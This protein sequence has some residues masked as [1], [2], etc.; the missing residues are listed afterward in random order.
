MIGNSASG[1]DVT[2]ELVQTAK[3]PVYQSRRSKSRWDGDEPPIGIAWKPVIEEFFPDGRILFNDGTYLEDVDNIIYCT[4]YKPS[5]P[6]WNS[7]A[8]GRPLWDYEKGKL[9]NI[10]WHSFFQDFPTLGIVGMPRVLTFRSFEYQAI[11]FARLFSQ[12]NAATLPPI[13]EQKEWERQRTEHSAKKGL[14]FHDI[15]WE[16]GE[17]EKWL[18]G[19]YRIAGL[20]TL[21]GEG[22]IPPP[23]TKEIKWAIENIKKYPEPGNDSKKQAESEFEKLSLKEQESQD[24][25]TTEADLLSF[26]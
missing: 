9:I 3:L 16:T 24:N 20:N 18:D 11:A 1:H 23:F 10:Y 14:K 2:A 17:T 8:N 21:S 25:P 19:F 13:E 22:R 12:R 15:R 7:K 5:Y 6:F 4:G 26:I